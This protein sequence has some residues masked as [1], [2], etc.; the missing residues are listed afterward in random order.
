MKPR[1]PGYTVASVVLRHSTSNTRSIILTRLAQTR[2]DVCMNKTIIMDI[3][4]RNLY[5]NI[6]LYFG[7]KRREENTQVRDTCSSVKKTF[8]VPA[9]SIFKHVQLYWIPEI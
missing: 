5:N 9:Y 2:T 3:S 1:E 7:T 6:Y 4:K 8:L